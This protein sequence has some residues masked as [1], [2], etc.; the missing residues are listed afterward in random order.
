[1]IDPTVVPD[2][3]RTAAVSEHPDRHPILILA[4]GIPNGVDNVV[5]RLH[6]L[7]FAQVGEWSHA[8]PSPVAGEV[9]RVLTRYYSE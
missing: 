2:L 7:G 4:C 6:L 8:L 3:L 9:I 5:H 1:M